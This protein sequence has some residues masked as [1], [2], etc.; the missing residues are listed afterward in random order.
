[1]LATIVRESRSDQLKSTWITCNLA[2]G[3]QAAELAERRC[4]IGYAVTRSCST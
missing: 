3:N 4:G 2:D 1:M